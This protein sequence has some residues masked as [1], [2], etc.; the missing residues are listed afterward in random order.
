VNLEKKVFR[1]FHKGCGAQGNVLDLF[2]A[3]RRLPLYEAA[4]LLAETF[5]IDLTAAS[6]TEKRNP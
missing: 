4:V 6:G 3:V 2:A 1:C 5:A